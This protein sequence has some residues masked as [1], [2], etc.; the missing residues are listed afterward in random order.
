MIN[1]K[2]FTVIWFWYFFLLSMG[3]FRM[4]YRVIQMLSW[5]VRWAG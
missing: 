3:V 2:L 5:K 4:V 1:D